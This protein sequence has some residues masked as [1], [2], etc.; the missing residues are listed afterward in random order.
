[1]WRGNDR[2]G[3]LMKNTLLGLMLV[4]AIFPGLATAVDA[5]LSLEECIK[6]GESAYIRGDYVKSMVFFTRAVAMDPGNKD[7]VQR[8][9]FVGEELQFLDNHYKEWLRMMNEAEADQSR[10]FEEKVDNALSSLRTENTKRLSEL[11]RENAKLV[12]ATLKRQ[13]ATIKELK[14]ELDG[15]QMLTFFAFAVVLVAGVF[16]LWRRKRKLG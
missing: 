15:F 11:R 13:E 8:L 3:E 4:L 16:W 6:R 5:D 1:M 9:A 12:T 10:E 2:R 7:A 14:R